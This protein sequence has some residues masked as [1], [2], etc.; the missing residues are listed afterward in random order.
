MAKM[1]VL[2]WVAFILV[3]VGAI[4]WGLFA[5]SANFELIHYIGMPIVE[6]LIYGLVG[7]A[8]LLSLWTGIKLAVD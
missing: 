4:N 7:L 3:T 5:I 1:S 8:G 6:R 2:D